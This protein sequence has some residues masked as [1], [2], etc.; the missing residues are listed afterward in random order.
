MDAAEVVLQQDQ[1]DGVRVVLYLLAVGI[2]QA[3]KPLERHA[4]G[5]GSGARRGMWWT[6][7]GP[8]D[9]TAN[10]K[11]IAVSEG[12]AYPSRKD[13]EDAIDLKQSR[14]APVQLGDRPS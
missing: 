7:Q 4:D 5:E 11:P 9:L 14:D 2:R 12:E 3:S 13:C 8:G 1:G 6:T 10:H